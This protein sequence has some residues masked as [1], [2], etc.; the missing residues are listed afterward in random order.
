MKI[1]NTQRDLYMQCPKKYQFRYIHKLRSRE[2]GSALFFGSAFDKATEEMLKSRDLVAA[3]TVFTNAWMANESNYICKFGKADL[4]L[5]ILTEDDIAKLQATSDN[6]NNS[7]AKQE[8]QKSLDVKK[9]ITDI[10]KMKESGFLRAL[11]PEE[12]KYLHYAHVL[13][14]HRKGH[15]MLESFYKNILDHITRVVG[16]QI[17][18]D[19]PDGQGNTIQGY[20]DLLCIMAGYVLPNGRVL[21]DNDLVLAD[22]KSAGVAYWSKLD[23]LTNSDQL[24]T[25]LV[26]EGV[27]G[28]SPTNL[29]CYLATAKNVSK[30][31]TTF[32]KSCGAIKDSSHRTCNADINGKRCGGE[33]EVQEAYYCDSKI[34]IGERDL[35][36]A[37]QVLMDYDDIL[38]GITQGV[39][40]RNRSNCEMY[41][42]IC[43]Y[44]SIC[45]LCLTEGQMQDKLEEW[46]RDRGE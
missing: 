4:E 32:C 28:I 13:S 23:D 25:Y 8:Y 17:V 31:E 19:I 44:K 34:V 22:I 40:P 9:L 37:Q 12:D 3:N 36:Q 24:D 7:K 38:H 35:G 16:T 29:I 21:T 5:R 41:G 1:S 46:K 26:S 42:S 10:K 15:L 43:E 30:N 6:L 14:M 39:Y 2:K 27:Q 45:G 20:I 18:V 11:T 33:W